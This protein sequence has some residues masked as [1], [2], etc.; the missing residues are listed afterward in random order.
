MRETDAN[1]LGGQ[2]IQAR[3]INELVGIARGLAADGV[4]NDAEVEFLQSWL[5]ANSCVSS[6]PVLRPLYRRIN[7]V[8]ADDQVGEEER[9]ELLDA[10]QGF[11]GGAIELG[12]ALRSAK[13]PLCDPLPALSFQGRAYCFTGTFNFGKRSEC[14]SATVARGAEVGALT[15]KTDVLVVGAYVTESWRHSSFGNK[16]LKA[17][18]YRDRGVPIAIVP[19]AHWTKYL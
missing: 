16:I 12:E 3:Q 19:E 18:E 13:L 10:L 1:R 11:T 5:A 7:E 15:K 6:Q 8:L 14:E 17:A 4:L 2:R 9:S